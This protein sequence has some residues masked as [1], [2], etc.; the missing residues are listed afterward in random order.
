M[1]F[2]FYQIAE[3]V[4]SDFRNTENLR[5]FVIIPFLY[6]PPTTGQDNQA[7]DGEMRQRP[8]ERKI[9]GSSM[10][11]KTHSKYVH[12]I[13]YTVCYKIIKDIQNFPSHISSN[14]IAPPPPQ[15]IHSPMPAMKNM[16]SKKGN[17]GAY[18]IF[19]LLSPDL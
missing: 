11:K 4:L 5:H 10:Y 18:V 17:N 2:I 19:F 12:K 14:T 16:L 3:I 13:F 8:I 9:A 6:R 15:I 1:F 7:F